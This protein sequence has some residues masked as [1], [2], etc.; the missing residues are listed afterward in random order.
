MKPIPIYRQSSTTVNLEDYHT[1][2]ADCCRLLQTPMYRRMNG[3]YPGQEY[4]TQRQTGDTHNS[5]K[6]NPTTHIGR[7][8]I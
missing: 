1:A 4:S 6:S 3:L 5:R 8:T 7:S 2:A